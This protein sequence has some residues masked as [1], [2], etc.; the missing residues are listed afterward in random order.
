MHLSALLRFLR[1]RVAERSLEERPVDPS[2]EDRD[3][4]LHASSDHLLPL[5]VK[6]VGK[7]GRRQVIGHG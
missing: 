7:L 6:L 1:R 4:Q 5:H 2:V 3:V